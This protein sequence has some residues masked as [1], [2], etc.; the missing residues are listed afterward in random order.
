MAHAD[1]DMSYELEVKI[2][3]KELDMLPFV[4]ELVG[5]SIIGMMEALKGYEEDKDITVT[6]KK[7]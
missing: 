1:R 4:K 5:N 3:D 2:G 6:I 7:K